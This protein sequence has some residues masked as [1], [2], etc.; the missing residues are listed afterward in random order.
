MIRNEKN[1]ACIENRERK[2]TSR[3]SGFDYLTFGIP[4]EKTS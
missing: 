3:I 2:K 4:N 1:G